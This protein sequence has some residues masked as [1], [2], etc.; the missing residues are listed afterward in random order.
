[1]D[2][3]KA[4]GEYDELDY[5][6]SLSALFVVYAGTTIE[7]SDYYQNVFIVNGLTSFLAHSPLLKDYPE[8]RRH[9]GDV[10]GLTIWYPLLFHYFKK[11]YDL[12]D[13]VSID[14]LYLVILVNYLVHN[15]IGELTN[16]MFPLSVLL[17]I[18]QIRDKLTLKI[19]LLDVLPALLAKKFERTRIFQRQPVNVHS[20]WHVLGALMFK[21]LVVDLD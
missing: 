1:M 17:L 20:V 12:S 7:S 9:I 2:L 10:D 19:I 13:K 3:G 11:K 21:K 5:P 14:L 6:D 15:K 8:L 16:K 4:V 18:Y